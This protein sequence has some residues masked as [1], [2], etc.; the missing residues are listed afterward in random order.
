LANLV[1]ERKVS[2]RGARKLVR[3]FGS[4]VDFDS[5]NHYT[6]DH[7]EHIIR[8][9][10]KTITA[11]RIAMNTLTEIIEGI[12]H[13]WILYEILMQHNVTQP[14]RYSSQG[15]EKIIVCLCIIV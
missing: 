4:E 6:T 5:N 7:I 14:N 15:K 13:D 12:E 8:S 3:A 11:I 2:L 10:D 1:I 9:F